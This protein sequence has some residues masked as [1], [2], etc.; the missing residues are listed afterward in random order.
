MVSDEELKKAPNIEAILDWVDARR[1]DVSGEIRGFLSM[2]RHEP[3]GK[4]EALVF[5][6]TIGFAAGRKYQADHPELHPD[7]YH[8]LG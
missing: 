8:R 5:L 2:A 1:P 6:L 4:A 3:R 7:I